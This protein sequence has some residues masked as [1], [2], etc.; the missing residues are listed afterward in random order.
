MNIRTRRKTS[1]E[2]LTNYLNILFPPNIIS[3]Y[4]PNGLQI[5]GHAEIN[6]IGTAVSASLETIQEAIKQK[7]GALIV[8]HGLFWSGDS[9]VIT[10]IKK[11]K[12]QLLL[13]HGI[14]LFA[15]H[16]PLDMHPLY[17]NNWKAALDMGWSD[18]KPFGNYKGSFIG[19]KGCFPK[20]AR[21]DFQRSLEKYYCHPAICAHGGSKII[22]SAALI[23]GGAYK[24]LSEAISEKV[25]CFITGNFDEPVWHQAFEEKI[26]FYA[27]GHSATERVGP[28]ALGEHLQEHFKVTTAFIDIHNPF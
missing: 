12:I 23:S 15:Y 5:E 2:A 14:S 18:L 22:S 11:E 9:Y 1:L 20:I 8:H 7:V 27:L 4:S 26:N 13:S 24:S 10:G 28:K 17:G 6:K 16:L 25:D 19:V 21:K 3:D